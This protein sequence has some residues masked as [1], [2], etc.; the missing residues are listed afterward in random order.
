MGA[1]TC[2]PFIACPRVYDVNV[3]ELMHPG[4]R[5]VLEMHRGQDISAA[6]RGKGTVAHLHS[7]GAVALLER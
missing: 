7:K 3:D 6:F 5:D 4:G 2:A 1:D